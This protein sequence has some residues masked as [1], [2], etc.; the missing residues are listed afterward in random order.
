MKLS[1]AYILVSVSGAAI[2]RLLLKE[3][4]SI[5]DPLTLDWRGLPRIALGMASGGFVVLGMAGFLA[6]TFL[7][8]TALS[9]MDLS[10]AYPF[11][12]LSYV[13]M[14]LAWWQF[15]KETINP[16]R[17]LGTAVVVLGVLLI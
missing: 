17:I 1:V 15:L 8:L 6:S 9:R 14:L 13:I 12:S 2:G 3:G 4:M 10:L 11:A 5:M 7:W 16:T